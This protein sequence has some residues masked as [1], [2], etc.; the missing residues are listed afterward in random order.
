M[1]QFDPNS[2]EMEGEPDSNGGVRLT[3]DDG[4]VDQG[5]IFPGNLGTGFPRNPWSQAKYLLDITLFS[6]KLNDFQLNEKISS[7]R[8]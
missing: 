8:K 7:E 2:V 3:G 1:A 5:G 4:S 6:V